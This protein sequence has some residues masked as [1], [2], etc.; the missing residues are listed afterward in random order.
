VKTPT[1]LGNRSGQLNLILGEALSIAVE[2]QESNPLLK[3]LSFTLVHEKDIVIK[4]LLEPDGY[5]QIHSGISIFQYSVSD[6]LVWPLHFEFVV[7]LVNAKCLILL[8]DLCRIPG[9][10]FS[11]PEIH[12]G[13]AIEYSPHGGLSELP[14]KYFCSF[15]AITSYG[16]SAQKSISAS[17]VQTWVEIESW[18]LKMST[19]TRPNPITFLFRTQVQNPNNYW[20]WIEFVTECSFLFEQS[21]VTWMSQFFILL[22]WSS[23]LISIN[24]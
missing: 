5:N 16:I 15:D 7:A 3:N 8:F 18:I 11:S 17:Q 19:S 14:R 12:C 21:G 10:E 4:E 24:W 23:A 2:S 22:G 1:D 9:F 13:L 6:P 20:N